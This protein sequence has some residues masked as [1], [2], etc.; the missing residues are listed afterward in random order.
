M[1]LKSALDERFDD[2]DEVRDITKYGMSGGVSDFI[3]YSELSEFFNK[4]EE[5]IDDYLYENDI[6]VKSLMKKADSF[7]ELRQNAVWTVVELYANYRLAELQNLQI[8]Q[9]NDDDN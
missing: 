9:E 8:E 4:Y 2:I 7:Q 1:T 5:E 3:Y 6:P